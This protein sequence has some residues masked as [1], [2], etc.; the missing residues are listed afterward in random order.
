MIFKCQPDFPTDVQNCHAK[1]WFYIELPVQ[2]QYGI[3]MDPRLRLPIR[4]IAFAA[5][6]ALC[7]FG[8]TVIITIVLAILVAY[9]LDP[10]VNL[11]L[12]IRIPRAIASVFVMLIAGVILAALLT[13]FVDRANEFSEN[14]PKYASRIQNVTRDIRNRIITLRKRGEVI[15]KTILPTPNEPKPLTIQQSSSYRDFFFRDLGPVYDVLIQASFFPFLIYFLLM[16]KENLQDFVSNSIR[17]RTSLSDTFVQGASDRVVNDINKKVRGF[18]LGYLVSNAIVFGSSLLLF[19]LF[20]VQEAFIWAFLFTALNMLPFVGAILSIIPPLLIVVVQ[21]TSLQK[22]ILLLAL[23]WVL[24][25]IYANWLI[26]RTTGPRTELTPLVTLL[27]MMYWG[28]L[29]GAIGI[30]LAIPLTASLRSIYMQYRAL[31]ELRPE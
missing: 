22:S 16:E 17:S 26:P 6:S 9:V 15:G 18:V 27:A 21:F 19:L 28:F 2:N 25:L 4:V 20:G 13:L 14:L 8:A 24:H 7:Y 23:C 5:F 30:F 31:Q 11:L 29:W 12:K 3:P 1:N 10:F